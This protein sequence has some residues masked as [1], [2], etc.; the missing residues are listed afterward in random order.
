MLVND[1][2]LMRRSECIVMVLIFKHLIVCL[3]TV[4]Y[5]EII[6]YNVMLPQVVYQVLV[7]PLK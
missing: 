2:V 1:I 4:Q 7:L 3:I 5:Y 6:P